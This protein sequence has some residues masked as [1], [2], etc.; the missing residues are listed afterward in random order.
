ML[1]RIISINISKGGIPKL[2]VSSIVVTAS[3]LEGDGH[4]HEKHNRPTQAISLQDIEKLE[5]LK[6]E[7]YVL[8][9]GETGENLTVKD[10]NVNALSIGSILEFSSGLVIEITKVRNPCYVLDQIN[11]QLKTDIVGRCGMYAQVNR[12]GMIKQG[13]TITLRSAERNN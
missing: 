2:P 11:P 12:P 10:L 1:P 5:E 4:N 6:G 8:S 7:G 3:G 9:P 13:D